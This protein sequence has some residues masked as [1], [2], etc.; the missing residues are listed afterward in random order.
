M[1]ERSAGLCK[2]INTMLEKILPF[3][4]FGRKKNTMTEEEIYNLPNKK[5]NNVGN[6]RYSPNNKWKGQIG[7]NKSGFV[8]FDTL[9]NGFRALMLLLVGYVRKGRNTIEKIVYVYAPPNENDTQNYIR[10]VSASLGIKPDQ[11][12]TEK[13]LKENNG[14]LLKK[15]ADIISEHE[16]GMMFAQS[17]IDKGFELTQIV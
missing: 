16:K 14:E 4:F 2:Q 10:V 8:V 12:I 1:V 5:T 13:M 6:I 7:K 11:V 3:L 15:F 9:E 17:T